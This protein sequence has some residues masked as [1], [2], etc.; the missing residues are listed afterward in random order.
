MNAFETLHYE[1]TGQRPDPNL[2]DW[3]KALLIWEI[4]RFTA[5]P[6]LSR[7]VVYQAVRRRFRYF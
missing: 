2:S 6:T 5:L 3:Q 1:A 4:L 7:W